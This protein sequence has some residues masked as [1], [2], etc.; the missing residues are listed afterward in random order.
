MKIGFS[1]IC[2]PAWDLKTIFEHAVRLGVDGIEL[3]GLQGE[4]HLPNHPELVERGEVLVDVCR[5]THVELVCLGT[6][7]SFGHRRRR[8]I[9]DHK[10]AVREHIELAARLHCPFVRVFTG[11]TPASTGRNGALGRIAEA[12]AELVPFAG[13]R[14]I[15]LLIENSGDLAS[16]RDLWF[17]L[18]AVPHPALKAC[19]NPVNGLSV[20]ERSSLAIP[21]LG[22]RLGLVHVV[23]ARFTGLALD[24]Y[25]PC[26]EGDVDLPLLLDLLTGIAYDGYLM[27]DWPKLWA[28]A[29]A[30]PDQ[31]LPP[32]V[33]Y[34]RQLLSV[35]RKPLSAYKGDKNAPRFVTRPVSSAA[36]GER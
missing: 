10:S 1:S 5:K 13:Q 11:D 15:T 31:F 6:S 28:P 2:C 22:S 25:T 32:A 26:G 35:E 16:S 17:L 23:D 19:W 20:G 24:A 21:R 36:H 14:R 34:L 7:A 8:E 29:L 3:R 33:Q 18:D 27:L 9:G 12:L 30:E 4:L